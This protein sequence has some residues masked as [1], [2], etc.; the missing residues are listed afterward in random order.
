MEAVAFHTGVADP[1][2]D[3][4]PAGSVRVPVTDHVP[5]DRDG[6]SHEVAEPTTYEHDLMVEPFVAVTVA[7]S[8]DEPP[9]TEMKSLDWNRE[10][11]PV[12]NMNSFEEYSAWQE[13]V[14][15]GLGSVSIIKT[16]LPA[17]L[18]AEIPEEIPWMN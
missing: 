18:F 8:P 6:R 3:V 16:A 11:N 1:V 7:V 10:H 9:G 13:K 14:T 5:S 15:A 12:L 4:L 2:V 17:N